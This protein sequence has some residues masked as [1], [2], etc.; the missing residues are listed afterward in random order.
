VRD[1]SLGDLLE[2]LRDVLGRL[3]P[4]RTHEIMRETLSVYECV[5]RILACFALGDD[6]DFGSLFAPDAH[7]GEVIVTFL[8]LL[9]LIRMRVIRAR[10]GERF[11]P[12][13]IALAVAS[14]E[15]AALRLRDLGDIDEWRGGEGS[16]GH[17]T[18]LHR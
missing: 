14:V 12:I 1:A 9:E 18:A 4:A 5:Q 8:A 6:I 17:G 15:E 10:Q 16:D 13:T 2:A 7:R 3:R 11:G